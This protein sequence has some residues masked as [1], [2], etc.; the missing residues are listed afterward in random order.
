MTSYRELYE[1]LEGTRANMGELRVLIE[2]FQQSIEPGVEAGDR[3]AKVGKALESMIDM[4][5]NQVMLLTATCESLF[6]LEEINDKYD[7]RK[8]DA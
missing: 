2:S 5:T 7:R 3:S 8:H 1:G 6:K 4:L